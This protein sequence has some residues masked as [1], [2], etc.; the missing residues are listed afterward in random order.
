MADQAPP[1]F[2]LIGR[3]AKAHGIRGE[4]LAD[5]YADS[6][7]ILSE[8]RNLYLRLE[9]TGAAPAEDS[10]TV[11]PGQRERV[12]AW[13]EHKDRA[14]LSLKGLRDRNGAEALR[15]ATIWVRAD[16][17]PEP[18]VDEVFLYQLEGLEV[19]GTDGRRIGVIEDIMDTGRD[20]QE[21]WII[22]GEGGEEI[23]FPAEPEFVTELDPDTGRVVIDPPLGLLE[24][25]ATH[26]E[27]DPKGR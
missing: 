25:Y 26:A 1:L 7:E 23:L 8:V 12:H 13:R 15:G 14:I 5:L 22:R 2:L 4:I 24:L 10:T 3:V 21:V 16:E 18:E 11:Q 19:F 6:P 9:P 27:D 20:G 17:L